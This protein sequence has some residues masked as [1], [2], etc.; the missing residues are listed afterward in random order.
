VERG[1]HVG[2]RAHPALH[3]HRGDERRVGGR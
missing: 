3:R 2:A 1:V